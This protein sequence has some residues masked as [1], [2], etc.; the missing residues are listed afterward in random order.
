MEGPKTAKQADIS[1]VTMR[2]LEAEG[3]VKRVDK[4]MTGQRGRP[5]IIFRITDK[6]RK[7]VRR[8]HARQEA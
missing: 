5:A 8:A 2:K 3:L 7:R 1:I 4:V 6:A